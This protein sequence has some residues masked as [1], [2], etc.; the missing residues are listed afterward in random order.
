M[1]FM[2]DIGH[3]FLKA[4]HKKFLTVRARVEEN[5]TQSRTTSVMIELVSQSVSGR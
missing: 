5:Q 4:F 3:L 2:I 1:S